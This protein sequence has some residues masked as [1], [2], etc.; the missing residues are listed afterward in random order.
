MRQQPKVATE[1]VGAD[2]EDNLGG[3]RVL[4]DCWVGFRPAEHDKHGLQ[5]QR[6]TS[7]LQIDYDDL[8]AP[9]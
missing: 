9:K 4:V 7:E 3:Y 2:D 6:S 1:G 8:T 5:H